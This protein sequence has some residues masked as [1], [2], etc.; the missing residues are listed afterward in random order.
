[1]RDTGSAFLLERRLKKA[2][3]ILV[4]NRIQKVLFER[5][6][7]KNEV[8]RRFG[9]V[10]A[11]ERTLER[12]MAGTITQA[13]LRRKNRT[14]EALCLAIE[15]EETDSAV[16]DALLALAPRVR[17]VILNTNG[18][19][20]ALCASLRRE[21]GISVRQRAGAGELLRADVI[22]TFGAAEPEG[23]RDALWLP[24]GEVREAAGRRRPA[25]QVV[26]RLPEGLEELEKTPYDKNV[27]LSILLEMGLLPAKELEV[28][29][30]LEIT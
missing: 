3:R 29:E 21:Y 18:G 4:K 17:Y 15:G 13:V 12:R 22:L 28:A 14:P 6:F 11:T 9:L 30:I 10:S 24:F 7:T 20:D 19:G 25:F 23:R 2:A 5:D 26:Y 8:F 1:M 16:Q 27:L